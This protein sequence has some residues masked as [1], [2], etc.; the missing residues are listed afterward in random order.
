L[1]T[2]ALLD[3]TLDHARARDAVHATFNPPRLVSDLGE[4][5]LN[6]LEVTSRADD[7]SSYLRRPDLGR[8]LTPASRDLLA[9]EDRSRV[10][11]LTIVIGD[12]LSPA[13][14]HARAI[15]L[16]GPLLGTL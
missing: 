9:G 11:G 4:L 16:V 14:V 8:S 2:K 6:A 7:R 12:G 13:A 15:C 5:G 10:G 3:F 1:P